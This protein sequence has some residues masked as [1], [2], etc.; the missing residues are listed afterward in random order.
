M[1]YRFSFLTLLL[2]LCLTACTSNSG[3]DKAYDTFTTN[4]HADGSKRFIVAIVY[5][6][7]ERKSNGG[8]GN[9]L[10][11]KGDGGNRSGEGKGG[12]G[13]SGQKRE[14]KQ[15]SAVN[16]EKREAIVELLELKIAETGYC[17][18]GYFEL[19]SSQMRN[20]TEIVGECQESASEDDKQRWH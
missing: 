2:S 17:R 15:K 14:D 3:H 6:G 13:K 19:S 9:R 12:K 5:R 18:G 1:L 11:K 7:G 10:V 8:E 4:I 20:R 16:K